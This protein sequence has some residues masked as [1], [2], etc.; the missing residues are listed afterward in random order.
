MN[1]VIEDINSILNAHGIAEK[2]SISDVTITDRT[3]C[4]YAKPVSKLSD[5][6]TNHL[7]PSVRSA[8]VFHYTSWEA[9]ES[10]LATN[11]LWLGNIEKRYSEHEIVSFCRAHHLQG[12]LEEDK[13][14]DP[15]YKCLLMPNTFYASFTDPK[16]KADEEAYFW[17]TFA[18]ADGVRFTFNVEAS[19]P[20]FRRVHYEKTPGR[21]IAVL[22]ELSTVIRRKYRLEFIL[23]GISRL[24]AFY[25]PESNYGKEKEYRMMCKT[26][27]E[28]GPQPQGSGPSSYLELPLGVMS[29]VGYKV[30]VLDVCAR[31]RPKGSSNYA[32][33]QR[34]A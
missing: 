4:D 33:T 34:G 20:N 31:A 3:I 9:A 22:D 24:C 10:I 2:V 23:S 12:Y 14:G 7:W 15:R 17:R 28:I 19:N 11:S 18:T 32:F 21:P 16:L 25:L 27:K 1:E 8:K 13:N 29:D 6:I 26:W 5:C 30:E